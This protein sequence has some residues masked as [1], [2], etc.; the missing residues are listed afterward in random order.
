MSKLCVKMWETAGK[1]MNQV[2]GKYTCKDLY[3]DDSDVANYISP[4]VYV[5]KTFRGRGL[6]VKGTMKKGELLACGVA[7]ATGRTTE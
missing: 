1:L 4:K 2:Q 3:L 7:I 5:Q 6:F